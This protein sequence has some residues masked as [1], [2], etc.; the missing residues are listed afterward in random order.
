VKNNHILSCLG[1]AVLAAACCPSW[2][3]DAGTV[4]SVQGDV[5]VERASASLPLRVGD[6]VQEQDRIVVPRE[7]SAGITLKDET[8]ISIGP[9]STLK[10]DRFSFD[11]QTHEGQVAASILRG[12]IRFV[13]G[14]I[15]RANPRAI[16]YAVATATIGIRG[17]DVI[18]E[19]G[20]AD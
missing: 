2:A 8:L 12:A 7:G 14:L 4:K 9:K 1:A 20:D 6:V 15:A 16:Q 10:I 5:R 17:T 11:S 3:V 19:A 18:V 13:S